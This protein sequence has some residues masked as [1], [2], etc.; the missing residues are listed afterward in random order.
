[1]RPPVC[2]EWPLHWTRRE[3]I[4]AQ[5]FQPFFQHTT[6]VV[7]A[8][9][10]PSPAPMYDFALCFRLASAP[11]ASSRRE[12]HTDFAPGRLGVSPP[13]VTPSPLRLK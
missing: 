1:M 2:C 3:I 9:I 7:I 12:P 13:E 11:A 8:I 10:D 6:S 5:K 4:G